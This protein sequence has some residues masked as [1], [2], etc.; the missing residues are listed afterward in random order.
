V[1]IGAWCYETLRLALY[2]F[3]C[4]NTSKNLI[5]SILKEKYIPWKVQSVVQLQVFILHFHAANRNMKIN[6]NFA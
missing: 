2:N 1:D 5:I 4:G 3:R 6:Y